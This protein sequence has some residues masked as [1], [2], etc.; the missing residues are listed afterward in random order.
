MHVDRLFDVVSM[1][2]CM[3]YAFE[4]EEKARM[5]LANATR[6]LR[7]GGVLIGT[8]PD[9]ENLLYVA[10]ALC[11]SLPP[12]AYVVWCLQRTFVDDPARGR[13]PHVWQ[14]SVRHQV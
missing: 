12:Y 2:F 1:Q 11:F 3:H 5:M 8:I 4:S 10:S 7:P 6:Y 9:C 14:F 13:E